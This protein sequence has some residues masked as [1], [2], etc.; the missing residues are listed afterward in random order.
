VNKVR[1]LI[2]MAVAVALGTWLW[3]FFFPNPEKIIRAR[4]REISERASFPANQAPFAALSDVQRLCAM[5]SPDVTI[6]VNAPGAGHHSIQ[7]REDLRQGAIGW[8]ASVNGAKVEFPDIAV[9][10]APDKQSAEVLLTLKAR[11]PTEP[12]SI[13]EEMKVAFRKL[14]GN[15]LVT[16]A[17]TVRMLR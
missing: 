8:R 6:Q 17:E 4:L 15:W 14:D 1:S 5:V 7:G 3:G 11:V 9:T 16:R 13:Y 2:L 10:V 12:D